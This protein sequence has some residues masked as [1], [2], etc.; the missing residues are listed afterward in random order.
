ML[1]VDNIVS[2][3]RL[4]KDFV[5]YENK[6]EK[7]YIIFGKYNHKNNSKEGFALGMCWEEYPIFHGKL[8]PLCLDTQSSKFILQG[9]YNK[10]LNENNHKLLEK[11]NY[12]S[13]KI[14][15]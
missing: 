12:I 8:S 11:I 15:E 7:F 13:D 3:W 4:D 5:L 6:D 10:A 2:Y 1:N 9:L 14:L